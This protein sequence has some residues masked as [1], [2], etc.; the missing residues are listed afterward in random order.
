MSV[1]KP[2]NNEKKVV[3]E[4]FLQL[5]RFQIFMRFKVLK[6]NKCSAT[7]NSTKGVSGSL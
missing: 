2:R 5:S 7:K 1:N 6:H 4:I 3:F